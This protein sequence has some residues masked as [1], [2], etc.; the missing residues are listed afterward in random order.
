MGWRGGSHQVAVEATSP[1]IP[2]CSPL[3][4][5]EGSQWLPSGTKGGGVFLGGRVGL[6]DELKEFRAGVRGAIELPPAAKEKAKADFSFFL[7]LVSD[8]P[9][10]FAATT[11]TTST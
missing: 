1:F 9:A 7:R 10:G 11:P 2:L 8:T 3:R 6:G 4:S 5:E